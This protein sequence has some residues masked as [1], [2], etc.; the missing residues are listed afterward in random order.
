MLLT[1]IPL[2]LKNSVM[3]VLF[4]LCVL[5]SRAQLELTG[6]MTGEGLISHQPAVAFTY[7]LNVHL[8]SFEVE[9]VSALLQSAVVNRAQ[10]AYIFEYCGCD[11]LSSRETWST[12][13]CDG[14]MS[15]QNFA[16]VLVRFVVLPDSPANRFDISS[17]LRFINI[18]QLPLLRRHQDVVAAPFS[19][20]IAQETEPVAANNND[21]GPA[22]AI[23]VLFI[24][25]FVGVA[26]FAFWR[27]HRAV[28]NNT[29]R[30]VAYQQ[31]S[32][33]TVVS[34]AMAVPVAA[35]VPASEAEMQQ[36]PPNLEVDY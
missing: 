3:W 8:Y 19:W 29:D 21:I 34:T 1:P 27:H 4:L 10:R 23:I 36:R 33:A 11:P 13:T 6:G 18:S 25:A 2:G 20:R 24:I 9:E 30:G 32:S 15:P 12:M 22:T 26:G 31:G 5:L 28:V 7:V 14:G 35:T 16:N 17:S